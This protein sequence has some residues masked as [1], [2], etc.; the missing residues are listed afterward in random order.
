MK[1]LFVYGTLK[2]G[3][4]HN[5]WLAGQEFLS[6]IRT[7]PQYRLYDCGP[8]PGLR[9]DRQHGL[10]ICGELW[11]VEGTVLARLDLLE[12]V[13]DLFLLD[14]IEVE[15][16]SK[17]VFAYFYQGDVSALKDCGDSWPPPAHG[18]C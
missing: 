3:F 2:R 18:A 5:D 16:M 4:C 10:A 8:Y 13:P 17:P 11:R 15:G 14:E 7:L 6:V 9:E 1:L 12:G